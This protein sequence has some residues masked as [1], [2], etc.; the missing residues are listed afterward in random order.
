MITAKVNIGHRW[1]CKETHKRGLALGPPA[2][3]IPMLTFPAMVVREG[4]MA[5]FAEKEKT[6]V[7]ATLEENSRFTA[8]G[9]LAL[10]ILLL[11]GIF[12]AFAATK[13][14]IQEAT[15]GTIWIAGNILFC[16]GAI[17]GRKRTY[18][19]LRKDDSAGAQ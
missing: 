18:Q 10:V 2:F 13:N 14:A 15:V 19:V 16:T 8:G 9:Q 7:V 5:F 11:F 3:G 4:Q 17:I 1:T 12:V 6:T